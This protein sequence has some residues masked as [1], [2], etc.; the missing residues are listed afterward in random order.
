MPQMIFRDKTLTDQLIDR[1]KSQKSLNL[2]IITTDEYVSFNFPSTN[3]GTSDFQWSDIKDSFE[4]YETETKKSELILELLI[5]QQVPMITFARCSP[6]SEA[7]QI[8]FLK[9]LHNARSKTKT[10]ETC[11]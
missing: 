7:L 5:G 3:T 2:L 1:F 10:L 9:R 4:N 11:T 6:D 8:D